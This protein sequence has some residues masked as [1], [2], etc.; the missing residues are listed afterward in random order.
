VIWRKEK[1]AKSA[2]GRRFY[3]FL[4]EKRLHGGKDPKK[5]VEISKSKRIIND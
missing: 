2:D 5:I 1:A 3:S 4:E